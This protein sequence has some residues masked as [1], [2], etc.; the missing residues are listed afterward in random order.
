MHILSVLLVPLPGGIPF[1]CYLALSNASPADCRLHLNTLNYH[2]GKSVARTPWPGKSTGANCCCIGANRGPNERS[3]KVWGQRML[4]HSLDFQRQFNVNRR[5]P[6]AG[7]TSTPA[8]VQALD[9]I[10]RK[11]SRTSQKIMKVQRCIATGK[12]HTQERRQPRNPKIPG[13]KYRLHNFLMEKI[14]ALFENG[15]QRSLAFRN[16]GFQ[17]EKLNHGAVYRTGQSHTAHW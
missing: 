1:L 6:N 2:Q 4:L 13:S 15:D 10:T 9:A 14:I 7:K 8:G 5:Y 16:E 17:V 12:A 3:G 11:N